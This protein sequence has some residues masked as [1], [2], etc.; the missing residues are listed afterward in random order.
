[1]CQTKEQ[2]NET[3]SSSNHFSFSLWRSR[4][5]WTCQV[6]RLET[7]WC[8]RKSADDNNVVC[9]KN[10]L[11]QN[12]SNRA[13]CVD[14]SFH[15]YSLPRSVVRFLSSSTECE[16]RNLFTHHFVNL[17]NSMCIAACHLGRKCRT[18]KNVKKRHRIFHEL[19]LGPS[20]ASNA[21]DYI[22]MRISSL[23]D[24][25]LASKL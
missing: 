4:N 14:F 23:F 1:M 8:I 11:S 12:I 18:V 10:F 13:I 9:R 20:P 15:I 24:I 25:Q 6:C 16:S 5:S 7:R 2:V 3:L 21:G 19:F 17:N 22:L